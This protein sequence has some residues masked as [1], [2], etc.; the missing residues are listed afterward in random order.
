MY[1]VLPTIISGFT[2][3]WVLIFE[4][5]GVGGNWKPDRQVYK[6]DEGCTAMGNHLSTLAITVIT[7]I[8]ILVLG[9]GMNMNQIMWV[10]CCSCGPGSSVGTATGYGLDCPG[11][12]SRWGYDFSHTSRPVMG[13]TQTPVQWVPGLSRR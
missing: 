9:P 12:E 11:I 4:H 2:Y 3:Q 10:L 8:T 1:S 13:T 7:N 5:V 6:F